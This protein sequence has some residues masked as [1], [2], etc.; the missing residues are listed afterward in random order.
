TLHVEKFEK[1]NNKKLTIDNLEE[2]E[3]VHYITKQIIELQHRLLNLEPAIQT[4]HI[5]QEYK[6]KY[7]LHQLE[8]ILL[9]ELDYIFYNLIPEKLAKTKLSRPNETYYNI[10][11]NKK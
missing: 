3:K 8:E 1:E 6:E 5:T 4:E 7:K 11:V 9:N 2:S 10:K